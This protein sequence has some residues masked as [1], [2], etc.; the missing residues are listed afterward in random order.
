MI[1][2]SWA[3]IG[4][5]LVIGPAAYV[6]LILL[7]RASGKRTLTKLNVFDYLVTIA[8]GSTLA[9][10]IL[11]ESISLAQGVAAFAVLV[12]LQYV[13][14]WLSVRWPAFERVVKAEPSLLLHNGQFLDRALKAQRVTRTEIQAAL[15]AHGEAEAAGIAAVVLETDGSLTVVP[16][17]E[18]GA[19]ALRFR[20]GGDHT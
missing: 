13:I 6:A 11:N 20:R 14:T 17:G 10:V 18:A 5:V 4:R 16:K 7:L 3:A 12:V 9:S 2:S 8:L 1:F 19:G 15:R